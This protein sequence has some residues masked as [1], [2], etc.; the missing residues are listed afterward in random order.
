MFA[1]YSIQVAEQNKAFYWSRRKA[2]IERM[3]S[4]PGEN[5]GMLLVYEEA[6]DAYCTVLYL[7]STSYFVHRRSRYAEAQSN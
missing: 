6:F 4:R 5:R 1:C 2:W 7:T 3:E